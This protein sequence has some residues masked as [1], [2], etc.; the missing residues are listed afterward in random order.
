MPSNMTSEKAHE[1]EA[2]YIS[3]KGDF[4][5]TK[6]CLPKVIDKDDKKNEGLQADWS[7]ATLEIIKELLKINEKQIYFSTK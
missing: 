3:L 5:A 7:Q 2:H 6:G 1:L 4:Q